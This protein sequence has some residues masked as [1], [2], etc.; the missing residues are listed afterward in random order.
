MAGNFT[1]V[2]NN[3]LVEKLGYPVVK[4]EG[5]IDKVLMKVLDLILA[6]HRLLS[7]PL[8]GSVKP[9]IN[10][11]KT[12]MISS[13]QN[14]Q[15]DYREVEIVQTCLEKVR[16]MRKRRSLIQWGKNIDADLKFLDGELVNSGIQSL[17]HVS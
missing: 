1:L 6:G 8:S 2:T 12:V 13:T 3:D 4:V 17:Y 9:S 15:V 14:D 5:E 16:D 7:H 10:P 11:Y